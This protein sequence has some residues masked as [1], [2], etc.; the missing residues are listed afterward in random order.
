MFLNNKSNA[1]M[2]NESTFQDEIRFGNVSFELSLQF[3]K[4]YDYTCDRNVCNRDYHEIFTLRLV[5]VVR[6]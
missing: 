4:C 1:Q 2:Q 3:F 5:I 6:H